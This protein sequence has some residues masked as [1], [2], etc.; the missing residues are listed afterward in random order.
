[1]PTKTTLKWTFAEDMT[2]ARLSEIAAAAGIPDIYG[3]KMPRWSIKQGA[4]FL[5][6]SRSR[7]RPEEYANGK[8]IAALDE[9]GERQ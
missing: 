7:T 9:E 1:M 8:L 3:K 6:V 4:L 2:E 5:D